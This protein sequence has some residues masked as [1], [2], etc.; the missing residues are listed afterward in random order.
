MKYFIAKYGTIMTFIVMVLSFLVLLPPFR[1]QMNLIN[2]LGQTAIFGLFSIALTCCLKV[3]DIDFS[4]GATGSLC[5]IAAALL[6]VKGV[7]MYWA[8]GL[9]LAIGVAIGILNGILVGYL[10]FDSFICTIGTSLLVFGIAMGLT[11]GQNIFLGSEISDN[12]V[13]LG[14]G[15]LLG[16]PVRFIL[17]ILLALI[18][19][20]FHAYTETG[21]DIEA[22]AGNAAAARL[23]GINVNYN[24]ML[25]FILSGICSSVAGIV[26]TSSIMSARASEN[27]QYILGA[28]AACFIGA[29]TVRIGLFHVGGT[30]LG[31]FF[32]VVATNGFIILMVPSYVTKIVNGTI[33]LISILLSIVATKFLDR[34]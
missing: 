11:R 20:L 8:I 13:M 9:S 6:M 33:L 16:I 34:K 14:S 31:I 2:I 27:L 12:F 3:G 25:S 29:S 4:I 26:I 28:M 7:N 15:N 1:T 19:W 5:G 32:T 23:Y 22:V 21:R 24:K 30:L 10:N 18:I 17:M